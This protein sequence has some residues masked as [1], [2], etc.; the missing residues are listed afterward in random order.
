MEQFPFNLLYIMELGA[1][2]GNI[3]GGVVNAIAQDRAN[4]QAIREAQKNRDFN[5]KQAQIQRDATSINRQMQQLRMAGI[6]PA[7]QGSQTISQGG[8]AASAGELP[9]V[10][11]VDGLGDAIRQDELLNAQIE[12][13]QADTN[14]KKEEANNIHTETDWL[15]KLNQSK[16]DLN[17]STISLNSAQE[18]EIRELTPARKKELNASIDNINKE[19]ENLQKNIEYLE[20]LKDVN[21]AK[22]KELASQVCVNNALAR[23]YNIDAN[24]LVDMYDK[25]VEKNASEAEFMADKVT[26]QR[27]IGHFQIDIAEQEKEQAKTETA[28]EKKDLEY[29]EIDKVFG[30]AGALLG[31]FNETVGA[32]TSF[33]NMRNGS[34]MAGAMET[35]AAAKTQNADTKAYDSSVN[36]V[37]KASRADLN[38][39]KSVNE[40]NKFYDHNGVPDKLRKYK[41]VKVP[42]RK[43]K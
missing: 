40:K 7:S 17:N 20:T 12:N 10:R 27:G 15:G 21:K 16:I 9:N 26:I 35:S 29:Y 25:L 24:L 18:Y 31:M 38:Y 13:I 19:T 6:N 3:F 43:K 8:T 23:K 28:K 11:P 5:A 1:N 41:Q 4:K 30:Y 34:R 32:F 22:L 37:E 2:I 42:K 33:G 39:A 36:A 14:K